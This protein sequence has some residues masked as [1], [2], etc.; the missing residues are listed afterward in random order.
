MR[1][2]V[3]IEKRGAG[4]ISTVSGR[5]GGGHTNAR[6]G[7]TTEEAA[8]RA[9]K[10]MLEFGKPNPDGATLMAPSDVMKLVPEHLQSMD[11]SPDK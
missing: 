9:A 5:F 7:I 1:T 3:I 2:T 6:A 11:A 8:A 10:L 4:Y